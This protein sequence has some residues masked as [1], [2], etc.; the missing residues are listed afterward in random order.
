MNHPHRNADENVDML[1]VSLARGFGQRKFARAYLA[2]PRKH[3][4]VPSS[5]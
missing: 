3:W 4:D 2:P 5:L 1:A